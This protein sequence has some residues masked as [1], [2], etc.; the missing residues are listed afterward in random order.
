[1]FAFLPGFINLLASLAA[2]LPAIHT[3]ITA[4]APLFPNAAGGT[5][6]ADAVVQAVSGMVTAAAA[7]TPGGVPD[8]H[9]Q[10]VIAAL[11]A[12]VGVVATIKTA[13]DA[14][15]AQQAPAAVSA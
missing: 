4:L 11:P 1:M 7:A 10:Q 15:N 8:A 13:A 2:L 9:V 12:V 14:F 6:H 5:A 3:T